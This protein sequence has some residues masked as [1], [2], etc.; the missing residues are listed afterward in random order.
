MSKTV[1]Q[2]KKIDRADPER[3]VP[4]HIEPYSWQRSPQSPQSDSGEVPTTRLPRRDATGNQS[5]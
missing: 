1:P 5:R 2:L 3:V 4:E